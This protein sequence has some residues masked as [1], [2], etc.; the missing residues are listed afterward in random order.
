[1]K[2]L[3]MKLLVAGLCILG[4][5]SATVRADDD[6]VIHLRARLS[7]FQ[8]VA[9]KNTAATGTFKATISEDRTTIH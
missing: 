3:G 5:A 8:E 7:G 6:E 1:M 2:N 9:P 4:F